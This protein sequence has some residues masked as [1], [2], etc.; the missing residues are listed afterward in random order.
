MARVPF[1]VHPRIFASLGTDLVTNDVVAVM[2]LVK[3]SY[4]ALATRV[5]VRFTYDRRLKEHRLEVHD[6]GTGMSLSEITDV[7]S[8]VATP[9]R[10]QHPINRIGKRTRR[11]S[12]EKGLGRLS[13]SRLG[14]R[15]TMLTKAAAEPCWQVELDWDALANAQSISKSTIS[16]QK[17]SGEPVIERTG[18]LLVISGLRSEWSADEVDDLQQNLGRLVPPFEDQ[19]GFEI[20]FTP[21]GGD[22]APSRVELPDYYRNPP[23]RIAGDVNSQGVLNFTY[24]QTSRVK[25]VKKGKKFL[26]ESSRVF[27]LKEFRRRSSWVDADCGPFTF[28][29]RL[30]DFDKESLLEMARRFKLKEKTRAL[31]E[32]ISDSQ[33]AGVSLYRDGILVLPKSTES[34]DWLGLNLR[35]VS[36][37]GTRISANQIIGHVTI[38]AES[39]PALRD[40][41]DRERLVSSPASKQF[42]DFAFQIVEVLE[43]ER[44]RDKSPEEE[45]PLTDLFRE[46]SSEELVSDV[47]EAIEERRPTREVLRLV[48]K[49]ASKIDRSVQQIQRRFVY[50]SR[51][52]S[53][54]T[55][56]GA[57][58][59][60]VGNQTIPLEEFV[61]RV[62]DF[63]DKGNA[64]DARKLV[65]PLELAEASLRALKRLS[66]RLAPLASRARWTR[67]D[68]VLE[69]VIAECVEMLRRDIEKAK[70]VPRL[71]RSWTSVGIDPG[72]LTAIVINL[73]TNSLYWLSRRDASKCV[74]QV[75]VKKQRKR[76]VVQVHD[77]GPGVAEGDE[78][79]IFWP[80]VTRK[81]N[82]LGMGLTVASELVA[83]L[84]GKMYL[85]QPGKLGGA[86]FGFDL[87]LGG[88]NP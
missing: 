38:G 28:E 64:T 78:E 3:N 39:N 61:R 85:M 12:G 19:A 9:H 62:R 11:V 88:A 24:E 17:H 36:R 66:Q 45:N 65:R 81:P 75:E 1:K 77:N 84:D 21:P 29:L 72:E 35:R 13:S 50:Y 79:R 67:K 4:D 57:L 68:S 8:V 48:S 44:D 49:T 20:W 71:P 41:S 23:Y 32:L 31:R 33:F 76:V 60:E 14:S 69:E 74:I 42:R 83:H 47:T 53:L 59:H 82:G 18:T 80:G 10:L 40:T 16:V 22:S 55:I 46:L 86:T 56:A 73:L 30:W 58:Q 51:L 70:V 34:R 26:P 37:T 5:D 54:G 52:A 6:N 27:S 15:L 87:P 43:Q 2:E 63:L 7:W 25:R